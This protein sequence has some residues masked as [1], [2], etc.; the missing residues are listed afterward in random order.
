MRLDAVAQHLE[1][2]GVG[3]VGKTIFINFIP[4]DLEGIL[5]RDNFGG[6]RYDHELPG[7]FKGSF[8][9]ISRARGY[10]K[11]KALSDAAIEALKAATNKEVDTVTF[12]Y[13][14]PRSKPFAYAPSPGQNNEFHTTV[15]TLY[16]DTAG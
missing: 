9:L 2:E 4:A 13:M 11:S 6:M 5:L 15:D 8:M 7:Y 16:I 1:E 12:R 3:I 10:E 14:R